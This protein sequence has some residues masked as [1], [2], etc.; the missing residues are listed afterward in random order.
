MP[1][2]K[3]GMRPSLR[4]ALIQN[5][6][7]AI[8]IKQNK[9]GK[10]RCLLTTA[11]QEHSKSLGCKTV[12]L[13]LCG[14]AL[15]RPQGLGGNDWPTLKATPSPTYGIRK[16][17]PHQAGQSCN[18]SLH[19]QGLTSTFVASQSVLWPLKNRPHQLE[20]SLSHLLCRPANIYLSLSAPVK[21]VHCL[22]GWPLRAAPCSRS[23]SAYSQP[24]SRGYNIAH[25]N[26][27][28]TTSD[29]IWYIFSA[30][31]LRT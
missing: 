22:K 31:S 3:H 16:A 30:G 1:I 7:T 8:V 5:P 6:P 25:S 12:R 24:L 18:S 20:H 10:A 9:R 28:S 2:K 13:E 29:A 11:A 26:R 14:S 27:R 4:R 21:K 23:L 19:V 15:G 17:T